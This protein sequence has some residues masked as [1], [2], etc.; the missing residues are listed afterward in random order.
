MK[1]HFSSFFV[2]HNSS[3]KV[4]HCLGNS[5]LD[6]KAFGALCDGLMCLFLDVSKLRKVNLSAETNLGFL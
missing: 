2:S 5:F 4:V 6:F 3:S 1:R